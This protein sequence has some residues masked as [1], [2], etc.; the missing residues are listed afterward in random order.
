VKV[1][2][3]ERERQIHAFDAAG[4]GTGSVTVYILTPEARPHARLGV[5]A[6]TDTDRSLRELLEK[7][8][9]DLKVVR[10]APVIPPSPQS[11]APRAG[12]KDLV[13]HLTAR[14]L[15]PRYSWNEFPSEDWIVLPPE[16]W[17]KLLPADDAV[18]ATRDVEEAVSARILTRVY[19]QTEVCT[20][21]ETKLLSEKGPYRHA[22]EEQR[23]KS[24]IV[25]RENGI[26]R[27]RLEGRVTLH[28]DFYPDRP[29]S[30][31]RVEATL[32]GYLDYDPAAATITRF[33]M[34][35]KEASYGK[36]PFGAALRS[37]PLALAE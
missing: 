5:V 20:A 36:T 17:R 30:R 37:V 10:G 27:A 18:A 1:E 33:R 2:A 7:V 26:V 4:L 23:L 25:A 14:K 32:V 19:P 12:A 3:K 9:A 15:Q 8:V 28:H 21:D 6:A 34:V 22:I 11:R 24:T 16:E 35:T 29:D 31:A 13:L